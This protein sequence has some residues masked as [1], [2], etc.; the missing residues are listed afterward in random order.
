MIVARVPHY[1]FPRCQ[2]NN[3]AEL[4]ERGNWMSAVSW[5]S[6]SVSGHKIQCQMFGFIYTLYTFVFHR[7]PNE[8]RQ[9]LKWR[10]LN[11]SPRAAKMKIPLW[12]VCVHVCMCM[13]GNIYVWT[14]LETFS[15]FVCQKW[16]SVRCE[17]SVLVTMYEEDKMN[18]TISHEIHQY[19][20]SCVYI[21]VLL[22]S[23]WTM[24][25]SLNM[26]RC[27]KNKLY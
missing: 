12:C 17:C 9:T 18:C 20:F 3:G 21:L 25:W 6:V 13:Y 2:I 16:R 14:C 22:V 5:C 24:Y 27:W 15:V 4:T 26:Q 7:T 23:L 11:P 19:L 1:R 10:R 8:R